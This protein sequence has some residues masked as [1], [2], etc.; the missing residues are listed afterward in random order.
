MITIRHKIPEYLLW[1]ALIFTLTWAL[2]AN[3]LINRFAFDDKSLVVENTFLKQPTPI[4][5]IFTT[6]YRAGSGFIGD[7]LY[8][9]L[10]MLTYQFNAGHEIKPYPFHFFNVTVNALNAALLFL[11]LYL[12]F[13]NLPL[14]VIA[15]LL[16]GFHPLH[17]EA[18][19]NIA[20]RPELL[21]T[22]FLLLSWLAL[23]RF[24]IRW[25]SVPIGAALLFFALLSKET[26]VLFPFMVIAADVALGR[27]LLTRL[28][29]A[30]Y[31]VLAITV[32]VYIIIRWSILGPTAAGLDPY[33]VD[34]PIAHSPLM[35]RVVTAL[36]VF[37]RY[38]VLVIFPWR[39]S[40]DYSYNQIPLQSSLLGFL[41]LTGLFLLLGMTFFVFWHRRQYPEFFLAGTVF[42]LPYLLVSN[43]FFPVGT[44]MGERLLYL[45]LAGFALAVAYPLSHNVLIHKKM[46]MAVLG[47][48]LVLFSIR[49]VT[50][51]HDWYDD[52]SL[53]SSDLH[54][55]S[56]SVKVLCNLGYLTGTE[57]R[58][59]ESMEYF[60]KAMDIC[61]EYDEAVKGYGK[62]L[63]DLKRYDESAEYY[64][65]AVRID[66]KKPDSRTDYAIVLKK[67]GRFDEAERE[68]L[69]AIQLRPNHP[70][71]YQEL[72]SI[73]I[74]RQDFQGALRNLERAAELGGDKRVIL[75]NTAAAQFFSGNIESAWATVRQ[76]ES[77]GIIL[78][79]EMV[80]SIQ[81]AVSQR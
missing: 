57:G 27:A 34:N 11:L 44:I 65:R 22:F 50:R 13:R 46:V 21:C 58:I 49:T 37:A 77:L 10:V 7:G 48:I 8:R 47:I 9:P 81:A 4:T 80:Q 64:S 71:P 5:T 53:F 1:F 31:S 18:V 42:L 40:S 12:M 75:N 39:L 62:R 32:L 2:Y 28:S 45:P 79:S 55:A 16:F 3:T 74:E 20:G 78:N 56:R 54:H 69:A 24:H 35:E 76:A 33:F 38:M 6:N 73:L 41:P 36:T 15:G 52:Y 25:W 67:L 29:F 14:A 60:R 26:A 72:S 61:P 51:N 30:R 63:Y 17:T 68:L 59:E 23:E 70:L 19:A 43:L 66:P